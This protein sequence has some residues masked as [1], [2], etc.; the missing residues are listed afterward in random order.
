MRVPQLTGC[1]RLV[2]SPTDN[3]AIS[4]VKNTEDFSNLLILSKEHTNENT[5]LNNP[6]PVTDIQVVDFSP[7]NIKAIVNLQQGNGWLI[8]SDLYHPD[9][10]VTVNGETRNIEQAYLTFK[11]IPLKEGINS[12]LFTYGS[13]SKYYGYF[14]LAI[15]C[16][17]AAFALFCGILAVIFLD[18]KFL[19]PSEDKLIDPRV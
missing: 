17:I 3:E 19:N 5:S 12:V 1:L 8:Y 18:L 11:A 9:W 16:A 7:N 2:V 14:A 15:I 6:I 13:P 10:H 4:T